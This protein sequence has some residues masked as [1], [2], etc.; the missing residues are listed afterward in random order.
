MSMITTLKLFSQDSTIAAI[1]SV[2]F[3][4]HQ[5]G[6]V[7]MFGTDTGFLTDYSMAEEYHQLALAG[8]TYRD[9]LAMLTTAPAQ[10]FH[11]GEQ[12]G[13]IAVGMD[14][15][16]RAGG[17]PGFGPT[18]FHPRPLCHP[19]RSSHRQCSIG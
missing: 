7:I 3:K 19:W 5:F 1:R 15:D 12:K 8:F 17:R 14:G 18:S 13:R 9:V 11:V 16:L 4:F 10:R 2:V 6:G